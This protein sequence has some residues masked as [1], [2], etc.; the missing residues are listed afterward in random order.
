MEKRSLA[1]QQIFLLVILS[2]DVNTPIKEEVAG[3]RN[4]K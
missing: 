2:I 4:C 1:E 3:F